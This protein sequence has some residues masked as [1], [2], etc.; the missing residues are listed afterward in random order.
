[1][2]ESPADTVMIVSVEVMMLRDKALDDDMNA[3]RLLLERS[4]PQVQVVDMIVRSAY[5][6]ITKIERIFV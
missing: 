5:E 6:P 3:M 1:M 4:V 2:I